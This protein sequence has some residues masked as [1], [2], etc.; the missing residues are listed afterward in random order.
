MLRSA[1]LSTCLLSA[2]PMVATAKP[3]GVPMDV[4]DLGRERPGIDHE[5]FTPTDA[6][7]SLAFP[8]TVVSATPIP[9]MA[10]KATTELDLIAV[11]RDLVAKWIFPLGLAT[12]TRVD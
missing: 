8:L 12:P 1:V 10:P 3:A 2:I 11:A 9:P 7:P 4:H 5:F 6:N